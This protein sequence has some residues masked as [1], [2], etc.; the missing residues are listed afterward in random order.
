M[1]RD[2]LNKLVVLGATGSIGRQTIDVATRLGV[3]IA[4]IAAN[5]ASDALYELAAT[6]PDALVCVADPGG[7]RERFE[8]E[9]DGRVHFGPGAISEVAALPKT[10][11][12][13]GIVGAAGLRASLSALYAGNRLA[14]ANK[15]SLVAGGPLVLAALEEGGG[16]LIP[17]DSEHS[18]VW[19]CIV[20]E[21]EASVDRLILTASG[22][23]FHG[24]TAS[25]LETVTVEQ[26]LDHPTWAMGPR[27]ST[28]S[29][30]L[31]N[32][33]FEVIE[34]HYL[35]RVGYDDIDVLIHPQSV[36]HSFVE[37]SDG[38]VKAEVGFPDMRKPIQY[39]MTEPGRARVDHVPFSLAGQTLSFAEPDRETFPSLDL[40][41]RAGRLGGTA[42][43]VLNA[44]DEVAVAWFLR[45]RLRFVDI[46]RV[47]EA[48]LGSHDVRM[49]RNVEDVADADLE[50]RQQA[51]SICAS[52]SR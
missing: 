40:G 47:V 24:M 4:A 1:G 27:I 31:M 3:P 39:A 30:T 35:F 28:D 18:A 38:V 17:V 34:A 6:N 26:A 13:N 8:A 41:Y 10:T 36:V 9:F 21:P 49:P 51:E 7:G 15:E 32:K 33:A 29:A 45:D 22:G 25:E 5:T 11:V 16:A 46:P 52:L 43:A 37:F 14:L 12:V 42:T 50:A 2:T 44:A 20:G 23:P 19:Q 48:V